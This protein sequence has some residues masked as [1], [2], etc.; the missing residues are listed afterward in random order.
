MN[1]LTD[2]TQ[3]TVSLSL[4]AHAYASDSRQQQSQPQQAK[5]AYLNA[6]AA[7]AAH[8]YLDCMAYETSL[9]DNDAKIQR[10]L[11]D[12]GALKLQ[13]T[14]QLECRPVL[15]NETVLYVPPEVQRDRVGYVAV[16]L[17]EDLREATL[18]GFLERVDRDYTPLDQLQPIE[19]LTEA[20]DS[21]SAAAAQTEGKAQL[22]RL[23]DWL[24]NALNNVVEA[25]WQTIDNLL[26]AP[27]NQAQLSWA[28][29]S[30]PSA[31]APAN[32]DPNQALV[33]RG[34]FIQLEQAQE[35]IEVVLQVGFL[36]IQQNQ[37]KI[38]EVEIWVQL[39]PMEPQQLLPSSLQLSVLD[40]AGEEVMQALSRNTEAIQLKFAGS[41]GEQFGLKVVWQT[42]QFVESFVI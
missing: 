4:S 5:Q 7:Y 25:G 21:L 38:D 12:T 19:S 34:K 40:Q 39:R 23:S 28:F 17:S 32:Q 9:T 6:L 30:A 29:R 15:P 35:Q 11:L 41:V 8:F 33:Q 14:M 31:I 37:Q 20:L 10:T 18:I 16:Q 24:D 13:N 42:A 36:P 27:S 2:T 22:T 1:I 3:F 26:G